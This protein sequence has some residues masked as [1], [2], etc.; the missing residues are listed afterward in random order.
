[1]FKEEKKMVPKLT[2]QQILNELKKRCYSITSCGASFRPS[3]DV[4]VD[5]FINTGNCSPVA[6]PGKIVHLNPTL[7]VKRNDQLQVN[8]SSNPFSAYFPIPL[9]ED[10]SS[11]IPVTNDTISYCEENLGS[12]VYQFKQRKDRIRLNFY[13]GDCLELCLFKEDFKNKFHVIACSVTIEMSLGLPNLLTAAK[14]CLS[15]ASTA[16]VL[17]TNI[18]LQNLY[19]HVDFSP[20]DY[21]ELVLCCPLSMV[22]TLYGLKL[23][24]HPKL[25]SPTCINLHDNTLK[26]YTTLKWLKAPGYSPNIKLDISPPLKS[27]I[28]LLAASRFQSY[29]LINDSIFCSSYLYTYYF[30]IKSLADRCR[31]DE[32]KSTLQSIAQTEILDGVSQDLRLAWRT[33][34]A[35]MNGEPVLSFYLN[36]EVRRNV[37]YGLLKAKNYP[38]DSAVLLRMTMPL[39][40]PEEFKKDVADGNIDVRNFVGISHWIGLFTSNGNNTPDYLQLK[41]K[42]LLDPSFSFLLPKDHGLD[43]RICVSVHTGK[44]KEVDGF[45]LMI[46]FADLNC[47]VRTNSTRFC[48]QPTLSLSTAETSRGLQVV[49]CIETETQYDFDIQVRG[50]AI[51]NVTGI[52]F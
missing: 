34:S 37:R 22:P 9:N 11:T 35:W 33:E 24:N 43:H 17:L 47:K 28:G 42:D 14:D 38:L 49:K 41:V 10:S 2:E 31:F 39:D 27:A 4:A 51:S 1:M 32:E 52:Y 44:S 13:F 6:L 40:I 29:S 20:F 12:L 19:F 7:L 3:F 26:H 16:A 21:I 48:L 8:I 36:N 5:C 18:N 30:I 46:I 25:G 23:Y 15:D 45:G 50:V